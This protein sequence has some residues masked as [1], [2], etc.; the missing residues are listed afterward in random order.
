[1]PEYFKLFASHPF[2]SVEFVHFAN[3][4][5]DNRKKWLEAENELIRLQAQLNE[6]N[7]N[8]QKLELQYHHATVLLKNEIKARTQ[9]QEE[10]KT[11]VN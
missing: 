11:L 5:E 1:M 6:V 7:K 4:Q 8:N 10:K 9:V 2:F 3:N